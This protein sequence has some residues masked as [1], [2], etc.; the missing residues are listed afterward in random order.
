MK[1]AIIGA[2]PA[3][4][5]AANELSKVKRI[6]VVIF[7][8]G[9]GIEERIRGKEDYL[10]GVGGAGLF[11]DGKLNFSPIIGGNLLEFLPSREAN[12]LLKYLEGIFSELGVK[13]NEYNKEKVNWLV[14]KAIK[15]G[16]KFIPIRQAHIGSDELPYIIKRLVDKIVS[17]GVKILT[18][19]EVIDINAL[20]DGKFKLIISRD[21]R[22][23]SI[24]FDKILIAVGRAGFSWFEGISKKLGIKSRYEAVDIGVRVEVPAYVMEDIISVNWDPKFHIYAKT[25]DDFVRTFCTCPYGFVT[26]ED[27][28]EYV[29]VNG[30]SNKR[31]KSENTNFALLTRVKLTEPVENANSYGE[32]IA[33]LAT[34]IGGG[35]PI[36]QRLADLRMGRRSTWTR[37][38]KSYVVPTLKDAT[39]GDIGMA[40]PHRIVTDVI[41]AL[42]KLDRVIP[43]VADGSTILYTPEIKFYATRVLTNRKLESSVKGIYVAGDGAG[44]SR[45]IIGAAATGIIA[46]RGIISDL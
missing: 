31:V 17:N 30:Y 41:E 6:E 32:S 2:G 12:E 43:G 14:K 8:K 34:T 46:A 20:E 24:K 10:H 22:K 11:S 21:G 36:I 44:V 39:P 5:F 9:R 15:A 13:I 16:I 40:L 23:S 18:K 37:I 38:N 7:E 27:H 33:R 4:L 3:G 26:L 42:E 1:T 25:Y 35:K 45:G 28:G 29:L 19:T